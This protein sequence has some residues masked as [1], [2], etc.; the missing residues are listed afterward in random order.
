MTLFQYLREAN[1]RKEKRL[2]SKL[3]LIA[4]GIAGV[5][6]VL[7]LSSLFPYPFSL[8]SFALASTL[9]MRKHAKLPHTLAWAFIIGAYHDITA[10]PAMP[11]VTLQ[12][13]CALFA[14]DAVGHRSHIF[15]NIS[16]AAV[17]AG[18]IAWIG[19]LVTHNGSGIINIKMITVSLL[20]TILTSVLF[21]VFASFT[22]RV[23]KKLFRFR[24]FSGYAP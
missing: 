21:I 12:L 5:F 11:L 23:L 2:F 16:A 17:S 3:L 19:D 8:I 7:F 22:K 14:Y 18:V 1:K 6:I 13:L 20:M 10:Y 4:W 9:A 15:A 24:K